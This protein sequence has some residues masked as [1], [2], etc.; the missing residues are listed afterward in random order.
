MCNCAVGPNYRSGSV[1]ACKRV[2]FDGCKDAVEKFCWK[3][4]CGFMFVVNVSL[5]RSGI[6]DVTSSSFGT[7]STSY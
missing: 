1:G 3:E 7:F 4:W 6:E 5:V 2:K